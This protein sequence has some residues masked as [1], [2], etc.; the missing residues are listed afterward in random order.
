M[1]SD[2][3]FVKLV[4]DIV[5]DFHETGLPQN[6]GIIA[7]TLGT[8]FC[9]GTGFSEKMRR[10]YVGQIEEFIRMR[11]AHFLAE[12]ERERNAQGQN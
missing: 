10:E 12:Q 2:L 9:R 7:Q 3:V 11:I 4:D 6:P 5:R 1:E 8:V